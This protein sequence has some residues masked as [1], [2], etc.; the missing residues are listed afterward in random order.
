M[1]RGVQIS[2]L[3]PSII[4]KTGNSASNVLAKMNFRIRRV[5]TFLQGAADPMP[6][7]LLKKVQF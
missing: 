3:G 6:E 7:H 4:A 2:D 1:S 5:K